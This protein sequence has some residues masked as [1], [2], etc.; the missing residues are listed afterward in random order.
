MSMFSLGVEARLLPPTSHTDSKS[1]EVTQVPAHWT[2]VAILGGLD[3]RQTPR[4]WAAQSPYVGQDD[5]M[6]S[7]REVLCRTMQ[8][9]PIDGTSLAVQGRHVFGAGAPAPLRQ[10]HL[11][12]PPRDA[13]PLPGSRT[14]VEGRLVGGGVGLEW[15]GTHLHLV[16]YLATRVFEVS[17]TGVTSSLVVPVR[18]VTPGSEEGVLGADDAP[19]SVVV[20]QLH[21]HLRRH[22]IGARI[23]LELL[24]EPSPHYALVEVS[25]ATPM[26]VALSAAGVGLVPTPLADVRAALDA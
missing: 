20:P 2:A 24:E 19:L 3:G 13:L 12:V 18:F 6:S 8:D 11:W 15:D 14:L 25:E 16:P 9:F 4:M 26:G 10:Y 22:S 21:H 7:A 23:V 1:G 17:T 5:S